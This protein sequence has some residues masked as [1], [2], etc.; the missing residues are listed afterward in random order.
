[1]VGTKLYHSIGI[2]LKEIQCTNEDKESLV[3]G[4]GIIIICSKKTHSKSVIYETSITT[5]L[6]SLI[7]SY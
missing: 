7:Q 3:S 1:M 2:E 4:T 5:S 6:R